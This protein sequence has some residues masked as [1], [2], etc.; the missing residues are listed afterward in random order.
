[1]KTI[2]N[3][4]LYG[5]CFIFSNAECLFSTA[6]RTFRNGERPFRSG[7]QRLNTLSLYIMDSYPWIFRQAIHKNSASLARQFILKYN[8]IKYTGYRQAYRKGTPDA[9]KTE[10]EIN[11]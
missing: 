9:Y 8:E 6:E 10:A 3:T 1:M 11:A 7:E 2:V 5:L 4:S